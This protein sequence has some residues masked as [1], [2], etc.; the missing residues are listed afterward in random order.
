MSNWY[1]TD[2]DGWYAPL[3][4]GE[5]AQEKPA[6]KNRSWLKAV[7]AVLV[8]IGLIA[9]SALL[10]PNKNAKPE[11]VKPSQKEDSN[12]S[13]FGQ[14]IIPRDDD[15]DTMPDDFRDFFQRGI[16]R[17]FKHNG[18]RRIFQLDQIIQMGEI[19]R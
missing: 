6:R 2:N 19:R 9:S 15:D 3:Q 14:F 5:P 7:I 13:N 4:G 1:A 16:Q 8:V 10:F 18:N 12:D 11:I 17:F